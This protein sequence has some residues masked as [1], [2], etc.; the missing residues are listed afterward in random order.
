MLI[1]FVASGENG[2]KCKAPYS[3]STNLKIYN[4]IVK[5]RGQ[6]MINAATGYKY[7]F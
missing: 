6:G 5:L 7:V 1:M 4:Y 3:A 2:E